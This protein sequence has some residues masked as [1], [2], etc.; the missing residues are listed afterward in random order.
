MGRRDITRTAIFHLVTLQVLS[1]GYVA[2]ADASRG[3]DRADRIGAMRQ[4]S[5]INSRV[6][7]R[8]Q[9]KCT[10]A[11]N[12]QGQACPLQLENTETGEILNLAKSNAA[13]RLFQDGKTQVVATGE[14][15]GGRLHV[16]S[17]EAK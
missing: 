12:N 8:G 16:I 10:L 1:L 2:W 11:E 6:T 13:M 4:L 5:S 14:I 3:G 9:L 17:I 15:R 7:I